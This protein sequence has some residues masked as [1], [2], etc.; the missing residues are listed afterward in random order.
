MIIHY[1]ENMR[2]KVLKYNKDKA[3]GKFI[4]F[5]FLELVGLFIFI[6]GFENF[7]R[8]MYL[9]YDWLTMPYPT[10]YIDFW[11]YGFLSL[12]LLL[13]IV[14]AAF[15]ICYTIIYL[16]IYWIKANWRWAKRVSEDEDSKIERLNDEKKIE[17]IREIEKLEEARKK[18]GYGVGDTI[19]LKKQTEEEY[20]DENVIKKRYGKKVTIKEVFEYGNFDIEEVKELEI[21]A[22]CNKT[23]IKKVIKKISIPKKPKLNKVREKEVNDRKKK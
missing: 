13:F 22:H 10:T 3:I 16:L 9:R 21:G 20:S 6:F 11:L 12:L 5:K 7:G 15:V 4:Y 23:N 1:N 2:L 18:Y 14:F 17:K 19:I 8:F